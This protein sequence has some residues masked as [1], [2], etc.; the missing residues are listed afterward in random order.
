[1]AVGELP[2]VF[3]TARSS[4]NGPHKVE[5]ILVNNNLDVMQGDVSQQ[6]GWLVDLRQGEIPRQTAELVRALPTTPICRWQRG[7]RGS[8]HLEEL[9]LGRE[10]ME[11]C[12][13]SRFR[14][15]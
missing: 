11:Q 10:L 1:M 13:A 9:I 14:V 8:R 7:T 2:F 6:L 4:E 5:V 15:V 3:E 12:L